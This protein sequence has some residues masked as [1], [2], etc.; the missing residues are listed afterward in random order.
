MISELE[1]KMNNDLSHSL[2]RRTRCRSVELDRRRSAGDKRERR[3][4]TYPMLSWTTTEELED[5]ETC[6]D[7]SALL[8]QQRRLENE[9]FIYSLDSS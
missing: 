9:E 8:S 7:L 2:R 4:R 5:E 1:Q 6:R 3:R